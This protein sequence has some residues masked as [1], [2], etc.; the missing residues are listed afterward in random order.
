MR[1]SSSGE[2]RP[3]RPCRKTGVGEAGLT[4]HGITAVWPRASCGR[5]PDR[6]AP[7]AALDCRVCWRVD[8]IAREQPP[9]DSRVFVRQRHHGSGGASPLH[10]RSEPLPSAVILQP[11]PADR[12]PCAMHEEFTQIAIPTCA[13]PRETRFAPRG[14]LAWD[15][16]QPR[17]KL[18]AVLKVGSL[19]DRGHQGRRG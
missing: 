13:D 2:P 10:Q 11:D 15:K 6:C 3:R 9:G 19:G 16:P 7:G 17:G 8:L 4:Y 18:P 12:G 5:G 1:P 14:V